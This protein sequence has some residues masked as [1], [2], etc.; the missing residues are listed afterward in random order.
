MVNLTS[1]LNA[2]FRLLRRGSAIAL[3]L[4]CISFGFSAPAQADLYTHIDAPG[5]MLYRSKASIRDLNRQTWQ[6]IAF[7]HTYGDHRDPVLLRI[8]GF[9]DLTPLDHEQP[10]IL[11][12]SLGKR[13]QLPNVSTKIKRDPSEIPDNVAQYDITSIIPD[14]DPAIPCLLSVPTQSQSLFILKIPPRLIQEWQSI[15]EQSEAALS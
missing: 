15:L 1:H 9:P 14:L 4:C 3:L 10:L 11:E 8:V 5:R 7:T 6:A 2:L 13:F 12:T